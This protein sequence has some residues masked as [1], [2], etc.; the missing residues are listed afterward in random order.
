[1]LTEL[2][3]PKLE[4]NMGKAHLPITTG[5]Q[6]C[7]RRACTFF[8]RF[9]FNLVRADRGSAGKTAISQTCQPL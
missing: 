6:N 4:Y 1:M 2:K 5:L 8:C 9:L 7:G 3:Q